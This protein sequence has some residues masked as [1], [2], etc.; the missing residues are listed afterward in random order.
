MP[1]RLVRERVESAWALQPSP[2]PAE[3]WTWP[4]L[5]AQARRHRDRGVTLLSP[6]ALR[7]VVVEAIDRAGRE[8]GLATLGD[9]AGTAGFRRALAGRFRAWAA[10]GRKPDGPIP[11]GVTADEWGVYRIYRGLLKRLDG[12]DEAGFALQA[13]GW[14]KAEAPRWLGPEAAVTI[15]DPTPSGLAVR[16]AIEALAAGA[17]S[18]QILL[19]FEPEDDRREVFADVVG[20]QH[21]LEEH[22][23]RTVVDDPDGLPIRPSGLTALSRSLFCPPGAAPADAT[24]GL[25]ISGAPRGEGVALI[26]ARTVLDRLQAGADP[27]DVVVVLPRWDEQ[28]EAIV[29]TLNDWGVPADGG[30]AAPPAADPAVAALLA[31]I[32]L[33]ALGWESRALRHLLRNGR[34][35]PDWVASREPMALAQ[36]AAEIRE[37]RVY[38]GLPA[39]RRALVERGRTEDESGE[40]LDHRRLRRAE[41]ARRALAIVDELVRLL[42]GLSAA[43]PWPVQVEKL[44]AV[45][46]GLG[47]AHGEAPGLESLWGALEDHGAVLDGL[48]EAGAAVYWADCAREVR[49]IARELV[50]ESEPPAPGSVRVLTAVEL[51]DA[52]APHIVVAGLEE[53]AFPSRDAVLLAPAAEADDDSGIEPDR[54]ALAREMRRFLAVVAAAQESLTFIVP[55]TDEKGQEVLSAG[56]L[57]D[58]R[59]VFTTAAWDGCRTEIRRFDPILPASLAIA[60]AEARVRA[61]GLACLEGQV[62]GLRTLAGHDAHRP[63][64]DGAGLALGLSYQRHRRAEYGPYDG[65]LNNP[66]IVTRLAESFG[67]GRPVFSASQLETLAECP[68]KFFLRH[69]LRLK[70]P[71]DHEEFDEDHILRGHTAHAALEQLHIRLR[72]V[73]EDGV[74][75]AD[76][77]RDGIGPA[78]LA[79]LEH[80]PPPTSDVDAGLRRINA[81]RMLRTGARYA[82]QFAS[83]LTP[84]RGKTALDVVCHDFEVK[85]GQE[86]GPFEGLQLGG[87]EVGVRLQGMI[88][89]IDLVHHDGKTYFRVID[90][91][92]GHGFSEKD[93]NAG[94]ALQLPLYALAVRNL[95]LRDQPA[96][97]LDGAY[98]EL[99]D[100]GFKA[101]L[102]MYEPKGGGLQARGDWDELIARVE[103]FVAAL[104]DRLRRGHFPVAP[105]HQECT[106]SCEFQHVCRITPIRQVGKTWAEAPRMEP[107]R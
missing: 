41:R 89:R 32:E 39:I 40:P 87:P 61:V 34:L 62:D 81:E 4:E 13:A 70:P 24:E 65:L 76:R 42:D 20:L 92:T 38:R 55:T 49:G 100:G 59:Q 27:D 7:A 15:V 106:R 84:K 95:I 19:G 90:Y 18:V 104:V 23:F 98:W 17:G 93:L 50:P 25:T 102:K 91:K 1:N 71:E 74:P 30:P 85:F 99:G 12:D 11:A 77:V 21:W 56:F 80:Q 5:W 45:A 94:L 105:R 57:D 101:V 37:T 46:T 26:A 64:L 63:A 73:P 88:D 54:A 28:A 66:A 103:A 107:S 35:R 6:A 22:G 79:E 53:G 48:G 97:L 31:A 33:P 9:L 2:E 68:Y 29:A 14:L 58:V 8:G 83:Y 51:M 69:V 3:C 78:I 60:P 16:H 82:D 86:D 96:E 67:P 75:L 36:A 44:R 47:L 52:S 43:V 10:L 72:D